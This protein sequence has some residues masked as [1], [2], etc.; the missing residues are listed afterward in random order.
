MMRTEY[1]GSIKRG[2][3]MTPLGFV[4]THWLIVV[5]GMQFDPSTLDKP[6][7]IGWYLHLPASCMSTALYHDYVFFRGFA[8]LVKVQSLECWSKEA[9]CVPSKADPSHC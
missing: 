6:V 1:N 5:G 9:D 3:F 8:P 7:E 4:Q 2:V